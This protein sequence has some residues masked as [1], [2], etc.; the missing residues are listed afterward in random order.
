MIE[1]G[2]WYYCPLCQYLKFV[3]D[4]P[5]MSGGQ[6]QIFQYGDEPMKH[7]KKE[8]TVTRKP[9]SGQYEAQWYVSGSAAEPYT[10]SHAKNGDWSCSC[11]SWTRNHPREDCK[12]IMRVKLQEATP[13]EIKA[14]PA[15][16]FV[17]AKGRVF[18]D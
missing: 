5:T 17:Q 2:R 18:R 8:I 3:Q 4:L 15:M 1:G 11:M 10:V 13:V 16:T 14:S 6:T 9:S 7:Q 12:H